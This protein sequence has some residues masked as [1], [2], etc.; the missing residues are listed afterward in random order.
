MRP[1][2]D[3]RPSASTPLVDRSGQI[4]PRLTLDCSHG[5]SHAVGPASCACAVADL[6]SAPGGA[7]GRPSQRHR[8]VSLNLDPSSRGSEGPLGAAEV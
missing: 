6:V 1:E 5:C 8:R 3:I 2:Q 4:R 7:N